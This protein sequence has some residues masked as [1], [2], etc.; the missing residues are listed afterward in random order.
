MR[1][2]IG[3][4]ATFNII[5]IFIIIV[6][7]VLCATLSYYKAFVTNSHILASI[8]KFEGYNALSIAEIN[9]YLDSIGYKRGSANC[10]ETRNN[11]PLVGTNGDEYN[12]D[13]DTDYAYCVYYYSDDRG[14][15]SRDE[16]NGNE[17][18]IYYNYSVVT[19][20]YIDLP[21]IDNFRIP[22]HT[23]GER[24]YNFTKDETS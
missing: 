22:V 1:Q 13:Q 19:Y 3:S 6:F 18:P 4:T 15:A 12:A 8:D 14:E 2:S 23:K 9:T 24:I 5:F 16:E 20:I 7:G 11:I 10:A 21:M 17:E